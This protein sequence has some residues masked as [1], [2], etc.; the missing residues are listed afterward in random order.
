MN[1]TVGKNVN[2][3]ENVEAQTN[4]EEGDS[5]RGKCGRQRYLGKQAAIEI[6]EGEVDEPP[7]HI[8]RGMEAAYVPSEAFILPWDVIPHGQSY[9][10]THCSLPI[11]SIQTLLRVN[12]VLRVM[13]SARTFI[14]LTNI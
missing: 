2:E 5:G 3:L 8:L 4:E 1:I 14:H 7:Q 12:Y 9:L 10:T 11:S 13:P 6:K